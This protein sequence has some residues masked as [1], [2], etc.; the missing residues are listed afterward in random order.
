MHIVDLRSSSTTHDG[1]NLQ[2]EQSSQNLAIP[3]YPSISPSISPLPLPEASPRANG[4]L[5][6]Q[7]SP[8]LKTRNSGTP[9]QNRFRETHS[10]STS[11]FSAIPA[12]EAEQS[13]EADPISAPTSPLILAHVSHQ[14]E[15]PLVQTLATKIMAFIER[16]TPIRLNTWFTPEDQAEMEQIIRN[17]SDRSQTITM[18]FLTCLS[19]MVASF[20]LAVSQ[21]NKSYEL[22]ASR[23]T[24]LQR[25]AYSQIKE[26]DQASYEVLTEQSHRIEELMQTRKDVYR[27]QYEKMQTEQM[28]LKEIHQ[29]NTR[30]WFAP[31]FGIAHCAK[32]VFK[33]LEQRRLNLRISLN[34]LNRLP[35][36][37]PPRSSHEVTQIVTTIN[38][39]L[40]ELE[41]QILVHQKTL[42]SL[43]G[44]SADQF[45]CESYYLHF[46]RMKK[47]SRCYDENQRRI[48]Q[49]LRELVAETNTELLPSQMAQLKFEIAMIRAYQKKIEKRLV[50]LRTLLSGYKIMEGERVTVNVRRNNSR[51]AELKKGAELLNSL[52]ALQERVTIHS[53]LAQISTPEIEKNLLKQDYLKFLELQSS[54]SVVQ[55]SFK[56]RTANLENNMIKCFSNIEK[57]EN[58]LK[59]FRQQMAN[60]KVEIKHRTCWFKAEI[61]PPAQPW[62]RF[63]IN[64][65]FFQRR[66][67]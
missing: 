16:Q 9:P 64:F 15:G 44:E 1:T 8:T 24:I 2:G 51:S 49:R 58:C 65:L 36:N 32:T 40:A 7:I 53:S 33:L 54:F 59:T 30:G 37:F 12:S 6:T 39:K 34:D 66:F 35:E 45:R 22:D 62:W 46:N 38:T 29:G 13:V 48:A 52:V 60:L 26:Q 23:L 50:N 31:H 21:K 5:C 61:T 10:D 47:Q 20:A 63:I 27:I 18:S 56:E 28:H 55:N 67:D 17:T 25:E 43:E 42:K 41:E 19:G 4:I 3:L 14:A 11:Y 57:I